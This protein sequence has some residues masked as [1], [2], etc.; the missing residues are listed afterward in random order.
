M[1][2]QRLSFILKCRHFSHA[3]A[4]NDLGGAEAKCM[5]GYYTCKHRACCHRF[6]QR[7]RS[8]RDGKNPEHQPER[9]FA[10]DRRGRKSVIYVVLQNGLNFKAFDR[11]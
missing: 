5:A 3:I 8:V 4:N 6:E 2:S 1:R 7:H 10:A 11:E 9:E